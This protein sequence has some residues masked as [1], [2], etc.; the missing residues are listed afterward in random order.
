MKTNK[1]L[2]LIAVIIG[3]LSGCVKDEVYQGPPMVSQVGINPQSPG[4]GQA[5][6]ITA[7]VTDN[8]EIKSVK[9]LYK[10][11]QGAMQTVDMVAQKA[12]GVT[13]VYN[14]LVPG[15]EGGI[16]VSY[17]IEAENSAGLKA[18][19]P[20]GAPQSMASYTVGAPSIL[21]NEIYSRGTPEA[22]DW[23]EIYNNS[24][25]QVDI[26]GYRI[27]DAGGQ[28]GSKPKKEFPSGSVIPARGF[29]II[30]VDDGTESGFGLSSGGEE[31]WFESPAGNILDNVQFPAME[32]TQSYGRY[33]DGTPNWQL[34][35]TITRGSA[36][37]E[38]TVEEVVLKI[39]EV[40]SRGNTENPD[41]VEIFNAGNVSADLSGWK[42]YDNGGQGGTKPK[43]EFP[44][45]TALLPGAFVV[46]VVDDGTESGFGLSSSG[47][48]IWLENPAGVVKD[49]VVFPAL[50]DGQSYGRYPDGSDQKQVLFVP[51]PGAA[52]DNTVPP[53]PANIRLNEIYSRGDAANP[54]WAEVYNA[55]SAAVDLSTWKI[56]DNGGQG[57][58]KP[59]MEFPAGTVISPGDFIIIIL[60][61][62][63]A[64][65]FGLSS[66][67]EQ[68]WLEKPDGNLADEVLF[69][70]L[71]TGQSYGRF[72]DG[73][74][75]WQI[76]NVV[77]PG[78]A[79]NNTT[80]PP[81]ITVKI[82]EI[83]SRGTPSD[84]DWVEIFNASAVPVSL[85]GWKIYDNGGQGGTKP[86]MVF[87]DGVLLEPGD[88]YVIVTDDGS[89][90]GFGLSSNGETVW[91]EN[92]E[93][94]VVDE[95]V[96]P[97]LDVDQ[98]YG[99]KPDGSGN[100]V[101]FTQVTKGTSN[102]NAT[103]LPKK[104]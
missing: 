41:W 14:A 46:I 76:L 83:Y 8:V 104:K 32:N 64:A 37:Y 30:V 20:A 58:T 97:A 52:N 75:N 96:F 47:E 4:N 102:N 86:K 65:G 6:T 31:I 80:P 66:G 94:V 21:I 70:A 95:V 87:P 49:D 98:S 12:A 79:N 77:T 63:S 9:L 3:G 43:K 103:T 62:G 84:P 44:Q 29:I 42:I 53:P 82:N 72:P 39:N 7:T 2:I 1:L 33:P 74:G 100:L 91:L 93:A 35:N 67:G 89:N 5:V 55:G 11:E 36:N 19:Y 18:F 48:T 10:V 25:G 17:Y 61:D 73:N 78:A 23:V 51:T 34:L 24:D 101:V 40:Y 38:G 26:S 92:P 71:E 68:I 22:P 56:Y 54:D 59:K 57:G 15:Q 50:E 28:S 69:P 13:A 27:Y 16:T 81:T 88:F 99:R 60:D 85:D 90:S 45:G